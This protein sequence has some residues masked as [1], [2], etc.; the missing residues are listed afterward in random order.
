MY[1]TSATLLAVL[2]LANCNLPTD[3][4]A[5]RKR[6]AERSESTAALTVSFPVVRFD[7]VDFLGHGDARLK[8]LLGS[9]A[10]SIQYPTR[11][12]DVTVSAATSL[13]QMYAVQ[14]SDFG[15]EF[16]ALLELVRIQNV[17]VRFEIENTGAQPVRYS[18]VELTLHD[19]A[20]TVLQRA[21]PVQNALGKIA[22]RSAHSIDIP[23]TALANELLHEIARG[24]DLNLAVRVNE[25]GA[26]SGS[27][28]LRTRAV[29]HAP[30]LIEFGKRA[31][32][33]R[34]IMHEQFDGDEDLLRNLKALEVDSAWLELY[35]VNALPIAIDAAIAIAPTPTDPAGFDPLSAPGRLQLQTIRIAPAQTASDGTVRSGAVSHAVIPLSPQTVDLLRSG[36]VSLGGEFTISATSDRVRIGPS[37]SF[38]LKASTRV[39]VSHKGH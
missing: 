21:T 1:R 9:N 10:E 11:W 30:I 32:H 33:F 25:V 19:A 6:L 4:D 22:G 35:V 39:R 16:A 26:E 38:E 8:T 3:A 28:A 13:D 31:V 18:G 14:A 37:N 17:V 23:A 36:V 5:A 2:V 7:P 24:Q 15:A 27:A 34:H 12:K 20:G 29:L